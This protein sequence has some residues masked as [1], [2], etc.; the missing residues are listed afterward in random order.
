V[1]LFLIVIDPPRQCFHPGFVYRLEPMNVQ[2]FVPQRPVEGF[3]E[4]VVG[5]LAQ[6]TEVDLNFVVIRPDISDLP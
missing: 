3:N 5:G 2:T 6:S 4:T 1:K